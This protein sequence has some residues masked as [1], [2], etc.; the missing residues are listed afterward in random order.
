MGVANRQS[1]NRRIVDKVLGGR[2]DFCGGVKS[3]SLL[4]EGVVRIRRY[5]PAPNWHVNFAPS[6]ALSNQI[7]I[8][9]LFTI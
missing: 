2:Y 3:G 5:R 9:E 7:R 8:M 1:V 4:E 6:C